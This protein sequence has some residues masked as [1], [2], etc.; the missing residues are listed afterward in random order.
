MHLR[1]PDASLHNPSPDYLRDLLETAGITQKAAAT[2]LGIT[3]RVMRYY[4]SG[5]ESATYRPAPYAIQYALE[6]LAAYAAKKR[7]VKVA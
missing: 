5:E 6:Q 1:K 7:T 4:L 2:T 3:D